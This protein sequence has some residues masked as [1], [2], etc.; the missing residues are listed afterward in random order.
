MNHKNEELRRTIREI[1]ESA[2]GITMAAIGEDPRV[3]E[4]NN[5]VIM[6]RQHVYY[7]LRQNLPSS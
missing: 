3:I 6:L 2:P 4:L 5:G 7:Y 1:K